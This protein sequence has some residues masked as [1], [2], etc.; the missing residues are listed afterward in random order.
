MIHETWPLCEAV[1]IRFPAV[2]SSD[3]GDMSVRVNVNVNVPVNE[4][5]MVKRRG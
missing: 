1:S 3:S 5:V 4:L 2:V